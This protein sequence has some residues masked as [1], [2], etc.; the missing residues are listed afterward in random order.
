MLKKPDIP[1]VLHINDNSGPKTIQKQSFV[2]YKADAFKKSRKSTIKRNK[3]KTTCAGISSQ[4]F[5]SLHSVVAR[6][7]MR[8]EPTSICHVVI[9][10]LSDVAIM[11]LQRRRNIKHWISG[12]F[13][14]G[15]IWFF[16]LHWNVRELQKC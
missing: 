15:V 12:P 9:T 13:Y 11:L 14:Y 6:S 3:K 5:P 8:V 2:L 16:S 4:N 10:S 7:K 1:L